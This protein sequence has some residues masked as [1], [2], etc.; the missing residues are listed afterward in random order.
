MTVAQEAA[1]EP[2]DG[3]LAVAY[4][5]L[6][7]AQKSG[8]SIVDT[9]LDPLAFSAWNTNSKTRL[10]LDDFRPATWRVC[11]DAVTAAYFGHKPDPSHGATHYL[12]LELVEKAN[13][14]GSWRT[15]YDAQKVTAKIGR[16]TF[17]KLE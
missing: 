5:I 12:N 7:R 4:V 2:Y 3:K 13:P 6:G 1:T 16:H 14:N 15:W 9:V 8:K 11:L 10:Y 17:L